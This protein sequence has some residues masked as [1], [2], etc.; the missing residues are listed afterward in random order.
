M[1]VLPLLL[2]ASCAY[3][4]RNRPDRD[5]LDDVADAWADSALPDAEQC[6]ERIRLPANVF[7]ATTFVPPWLTSTR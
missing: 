4:T 2:L 7:G 3:G 1:R 5:V 6:F